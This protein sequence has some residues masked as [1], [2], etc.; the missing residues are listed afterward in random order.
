MQSIIGNLWLDHRA[1]WGGFLLFW[2]FW[3]SIATAQTPG[4][5]SG[6]IRAWYMADSI[7]V[8]NGNQERSNLPDCIPGGGAGP[9]F[10]TPRAATDFYEVAANANGNHVIHLNDEYFAIDQSLNINDATDFSEIHVF[11]AYRPRTTGSSALWGNGLRTAGQPHIGRQAYV[12]DISDG[13]GT[14][15]VGFPHTGAALDSYLNHVNIKEA[16]FL[17]VLINGEELLNT[18]MATANATIVNPNDVSSSMFIGI[19]KNRNLNSPSNRPKINFMEIAVYAGALTPIEQQK[20]T[21]H[22]G[23]RYGLSLAHDYVLSDGSVAWAYNHGTTSYNHNT[24]G[25]ANDVGTT[26]Q[27]GALQQAQ[28]SSAYDGG[29]LTISAGA[30]FGADTL[31]RSLV[32]GH[33]DENIGGTPVTLGTTPHFFAEGMRIARIWRCE[34]MGGYTDYELNFDQS[35]VNLLPTGFKGDA[36]VLLV[37][38]DPNFSTGVQGY[39]LPSNSNGGLSASEISFGAGAHGVKYMT[40]ARM[41]T[42]LWVKADGVGHIINNGQV[43]QW[44][45]QNYG[46]NDLS[47]KGI[48]G[49]GNGA[50]SNNDRPDLLNASPNLANRSSIMNHNPYVQFNANN[51]RNYVEQTHLQG[52]GRNQNTTFMVVRRDNNGL[53]DEALLSYATRNNNGGTQNNGNTFL[54]TQPDDLRLAINGTSNNSWRNINEDITNNLPTLFAY[55]RGAGQNDWIGINGAISTQSHKN[56]NNVKENGA[57]VLGQEQDDPLDDIEKYVAAQEFEGDIAEVIV[58]GS[59]LDPIKVRQVR[60]YLSLKYGILLEDD[61]TYTLSNGDSSWISRDHPNYYKNIA[62]IGRDDRFQLKQLKSTSQRPEADSVVLTIGTSNFPSD[63]SHLVWGAST[64]GIHD[65]FSTTGAPPSFTISGRHW[66][67]SNY[68]D[69][70]SNLTVQ[71]KIP[72]NTPNL[73]GAR[74]IVGTDDDFSNDTTFYTGSTGNGL[75]TFTGV[76]LDD[77]AHFTLGF[78]TE[79]LFSNNDQGSPGTFEACWRS[80]VTFRYTDLPAVPE[81]VRFGKLPNTLFPVEVPLD[82]IRFTSQDSVVTGGI[83]LYSGLMTFNLLDSAATGTVN[84]LDSNGNILFATTEPLVIHNPVVD[85]QPQTIPLCADELVPLLGYPNG[86]VFSSP[87]DTAIIVDSSTILR[88]YMFDGMKAGWTADHMDSL[89]VPVTYT[90]TAQYTSGEFCL[91]PKVVHRT[92]TVRDNRLDNVDFD[93]V[94]RRVGTNNNRML[95]VN[96]QT[97][98]QSSPNLLSGHFNSSFTFA[99]SYITTQSEFLAD[100]APQAN[101]VRFEFNNQGCLASDIDTIYVYNEEEIPGLPNVLCRAANGIPFYRDLGNPATIYSSDTLSQSGPFIK[102]ERNVIARITTNPSI[103]GLV[104]TVLGNPAGRDTFILTPSLLPNSVDSIIVLMQFATVRT[105]R[106]TNGTTTIDTI[107]SN[108]S[109]TLTSTIR[110]VDPS[111]VQVDPT[112]VGSF[113]TNSNAIPLSSSPPFPIGGS[114]IYRVYGGLGQ[115]SPTDSFPLQGLPLLNDTIFVAADQY[116]HMVP[117]ANNDLSLRL[118]YEVDQYG[119]IDRDTAHVLLVAPISVAITSGSPYCL[120]ETAAALQATAVGSAIR[121]GNGHFTP[122]AWLDTLGNLDLSILGPGTY[123]AEYRITD[124]TYNCTSVDTHFIEVRQP[125]Q[126]DLLLDSSA[127]NTSFCGSDTVVLMTVVVDTAA[128]VDSVGFFGAG[129]LGNVFNPNVVFTN[130][131]NGTSGTSILWTLTV[132]SF[133]CRNADTVTITVIQPPVISIDSAFN[134][135]GRTIGTT[136]VRHAYCHN[137]LRFSVEPFPANYNTSPNRSFSGRGISVVGNNVEYDPRAVPSGS[138][139]TVYYTYIDALG[140]ANTDFTLI[141]IDTVPEVELNGLD[142]AYCVNYD[143]VHL[144]GI[145]IPGQINTTFQFVGSGLQAGSGIFD[146][147]Q[148][149]PGEHLLRYEFVDN[150]SCKGEDIDTIMVHALP[151][152]LPGG[153]DP[154]YCTGDPDDQLSSLNDPSGS[155]FFWGM[156]IIDSSGILRPDTSRGN[157]VLGPQQIYYAYTDTNRCTNIDSTRI[158]INATP[159][160]TVNG[161]DSTYCFNGGVDQITL[162]YPAQIFQDTGYRN[163]SSSARSLQF[164]PGE[165][166]PGHKNFLLAYTDPTTLCSDTLRGYTYVHPDSTPPP[167]ALDTLYCALQAI[168]TLANAVGGIFSG[169]GVIDLDTTQGL[170]GFNPTLAGAGQHTITYTVENSFTHTL[171]SGLMDTLSCTSKS[172]AVAIVRPMPNASITNLTFDFCSNDT[173]QLLQPTLTSDTSIQHVFSSV[174]GR[175]LNRRIFVRL[176]SVLVGTRWFTDSVFAT[177]YYFDANVVN[178]QVS[179]TRYPISH[180]A[181]NGFGCADTAQYTFRVQNYVPASFAID[182]VYCQSTDSLPL[183]GLPG[184]GTFT[185][186]GTTIPLNPIN[187]IPYFYPIPNYSSGVAVTTYDTLRYA[188]NDGVCQ[189]DTAVIVR[190]NPTPVLN[191][192][193]SVGRDTFCL[194]TGIVTLIPN[195]SGGNFSGRGVPFGTNTFVP[196]NAGRGGHLIEYELADSLT[197]CGDIIT[198]TLYVYAMPQLDYEVVGGCQLDSAWFVPDNNLLDLDRVVGNRVVDSITDIQWVFAS[199]VTLQ[200]TADSN[201]IDSVA[202]RYTSPGVYYTQLIVANQVHCVDTQT[203]RLVISPT[204]NSYPYD[205]SFENGHGNWYAESRDS[206]HPLLWEHGVDNTNGG[207]GNDPSNHIWATALNQAYQAEEDAWVYSPC[208]DLDSLDR[209]MI[210]LDYWS[211]TREMDGTLLEYQA[212]DGSWQPLG[213][214]GR[215]IGWFNSDAIAGRPGDPHLYPVGWTGVTNGW[216][217]GRYKLDDFRGNQNTLRLRMA[218]GSPQVPL[219]IFYDGFAFDNVWIGNRTR[220]VL[221]ETTATISEPNMAGSNNHVYNLVH[222]TTL[223]KDVI[224]MQYHVYS[225]NAVDE[226]YEQ[227]IPLN[228]QRVSVFRSSEAGRAYIDGAFSER[229]LSI[230]LTDVDFENDMLEDAKF[231]IDL[232]PLEHIGNFNTFQ[233]KA[234]VT[235]LEDMPAGDYYVYLTITED[236]L[237]YSNTADY[238]DQLQAVVRH[239]NGLDGLVQGAWTAGDTATVELV[240]NYSGENHI[241]YRPGRFQGVAFIQQGDS[242]IY[243]AA[244]TRDVSGY[245]VGVD[246]TIP[247]VQAQYNELTNMVL[248]PNPNRGAFNLRFETPL[249]Q[250]YDWKLLDLRGVTVQTGRIEAGQDGAELS[251]GMVPTGAYI[252]LLYNDQVFTQRQVVIQR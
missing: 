211:D 90:Y 101:R 221:L 203:V 46:I 31:M 166:V 131:N 66:R 75:I 127:T 231:A 233:L 21:T 172:Q 168:D 98:L 139:D 113:C 182:T 199:G 12:K 63:L 18:P 173:A 14:N 99:G 184:N 242:I 50:V 77:G 179:S 85:F 42:A 169:L 106:A 138:I 119:C 71:F 240:W 83:K 116:Q 190:I 125:L 244:T 91:R 121:P 137:A 216:K 210:S 130:L 112:F 10:Y 26:A 13:S 89:D 209:P 224:L 147:S 243:Q 146:P 114:S 212:A 6:N 62:G 213:E 35:L 39:R 2:L 195:R 128:L 194:G 226:F 44:S 236:S 122:Q 32:V 232:G 52:L 117:N 176:D 104:N 136:Q 82:S 164:D 156:A 38:D 160:L 219:P 11:M 105:Q 22:M 141:Q 102:L 225:P 24:I 19:D 3:A 170:Q 206:T 92:L 140:C 230:D 157:A 217:N 108:A 25:I 252:L 56:G 118:V 69:K 8:T 227:N 163:F 9:A 205:E 191:Y 53:G 189:G 81:R 151:P 88:T 183:N 228:N 207:F 29:Y 142:S 250:A 175:I 247:V 143:T 248:F 33:N 187:G 161:L 79:F 144:T 197:G 60:S 178:P 45:D 234:K 177:N 110:L 47:G 241:T 16:D 1:Q 135:R 186:N 54:V 167:P 251:S 214:L 34:Q 64:T 107:F 23:I 215:G 120:N 239:N 84:F 124:L 100:L 171:G 95:G 97:L 76:T 74:L 185:L 193:N 222:H 192:T 159:T 41:E 15:R 153:I 155:Y 218:F 59:R 28:S 4:G 165:N 67:V 180:V 80:N 246:P 30:T 238:P 196:D 111:P 223:N 145:P 229:S 61:F 126:V 57:L 109:I 20:I 162:S 93:A 17:R 200:G 48:T 123:A 174:N 96:N 154:Q 72:N 181:T 202:Y 86:G 27:A 94:Y 149:L 103:P 55:A 133:G 43:E 70:V 36:V 150:F 158:F 204:I 208:F 115:L 152:P 245:W 237:M 5:V 37:A 132:D 51:R 7:P 198:K 235:A 78:D 73:A 188:Y 148:V 220:N 129:V 65:S 249:K 68:Q 40:I 201:R 58:M 49:T 87:V 134:G